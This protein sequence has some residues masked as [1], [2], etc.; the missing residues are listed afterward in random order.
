MIAVLVLASACGDD[1]ADD[2]EPDEGTGGSAEIEQISIEVDD[3]TFDALAAGPEDGEAVLLLHGFPQTSLVYEQQLLALAEAGYRGI[4]PDQRGY[5]PGARPPEVED[6]QIPDLVGDVVG[7]ADSLGIDQF[8]LV[9]H[10]WGGMVAW[11]VAGREPD[12]LRSLT[13]LGTPHPEPYVAAL[14]DPSDEQ[15][16]MSTYISMLTADGSEQAL[17]DDDQALLK[18]IFEASGMPEGEEEPYLEA[19]D[20]PEITTGAVNWYKATADGSILDIGRITAPTLY[21]W[22]TEDVALGRTAAEGTEDYVD[23]EYEFVELEG[24]SH[25][26]QEE[27]PDELNTRL[28]EHL[29]ANS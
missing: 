6:Y 27:V 9:G 5:S 17:L 24:V 7:M 25:W 16:T 15:G 13:V 26:I 19:L 4:A 20:N 22:S 11:H 23:G 10:D 14:S 18:T 12:R 8:H 2:A 21:I 29:D 3:M 1:A 28:L